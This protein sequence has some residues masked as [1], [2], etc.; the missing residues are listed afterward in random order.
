[1]LSKDSTRKGRM[2]E[3]FVCSFE[4]I[5]GRYINKKRDNFPY[6]MREGS[7]GD[8]V[9]FFC[10]NEPKA[11]LARDLGDRFQSSECAFWHFR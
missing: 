10:S 3:F 2:N 4:G 1:M 5:Y 7:V 9:V 6:G 11:G 8:G